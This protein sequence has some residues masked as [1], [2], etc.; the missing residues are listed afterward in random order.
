MPLKAIQNAKDAEVTKPKILCIGPAGVGKTAQFL[1]LPGK[2][3][4]YI[5][6]PNSVDTLKGFDVDFL[7]FI[8]DKEDLNLA[9]VALAAGKADKPRRNS[10]PQTYVDWEADFDERLEKNFFDAYDWISIDGCTTLSEI[11]MDRI[12]WINGRLGKQPEQAD[13]AAEMN[14]FKNIFRTLTNLKSN[15]YCTA[16]TEIQRDETT[17]KTYAQLVMTGRNR[18]RLP[19]RFSQIYGLEVST[20]EKGKPIWQAHTIQ[21]KMHP[22]VR[23]TVKGL[24]PIEDVTIDWSKNPIGQ[25]IGRFCMK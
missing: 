6:D 21:D 18:T 14:T 2:K 7:P 3:F 4:A 22:S 24:Q 1:T 8:P 15:L 25:G 20:G 16:H 10:T 11:I 17:A 12:Q 23:T 5:F 19:M 9:V 13:Y